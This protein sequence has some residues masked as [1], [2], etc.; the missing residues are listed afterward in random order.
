MATDTPGQNGHRAGRNRQW[1]RGSHTPAGSLARIPPGWR[2]KARR[3]AAE[4]DMGLSEWLRALLLREFER[5]RKAR[6]RA[7]AKG[8]AA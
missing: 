5:D 6:A 2:A 7:A 3:L 1:E 8:G 4:R